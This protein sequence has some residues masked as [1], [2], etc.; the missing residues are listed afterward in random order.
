M[1]ELNHVTI[2][3]NTIKDWLIAG[4]D[5]QDKKVSQS[6]KYSFHF[7]L[8]TG[9]KFQIIAENTELKKLKKIT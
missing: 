8:E 9:R 3:V 2:D 4:Q 6:S 1:D 7:S 5:C